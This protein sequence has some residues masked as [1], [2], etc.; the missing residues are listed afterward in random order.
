MEEH[1]KI[2][3]NSTFD[4]WILNTGIYQDGIKEWHEGT[5]LFIGGF[6]PL[7]D[8]INNLLELILIKGNKQKYFEEILRRLTT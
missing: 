8:Q 7:E 5:V 1:H 3:Y 4:M 2:I 6:L